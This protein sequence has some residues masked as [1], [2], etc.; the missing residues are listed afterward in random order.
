MK[1]FM[2]KKEKEIIE[3]V[4]DEGKFWVYGDKE[5]CFREDTVMMMLLALREI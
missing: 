1:I 2:N 5:A 3:K 4:L